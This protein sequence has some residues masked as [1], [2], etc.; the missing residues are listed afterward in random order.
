[1]SSRHWFWAIP[2]VVLLLAAA[3]L[4]PP[5]NVPRAVAAAHVTV[6]V[7]RTTP[8]GPSQLALGVTH[9][10]YSLDP[11]G[12][13]TAVASG[14]ALL[15]AATVYQ[16]QSIYG[17]GATNPEPSPGVYDWSNLDQRL[18][19]IRA[20]G[21]TPVITLCCA[22]DWMTSLDTPTSSD[23]RLPPTMAHYADFANLA[24]QVALRYPDVKYYQVWNEM[25][26]FW[27][28][29]TNNW[30]YAAYTSMYNAVYDALK[31]VSPD[32]KV[33]G[34]YL[35]LEGTGASSLGVP[36]TW[37]TA[38]PITARNRQV[39]TYWL[40]NKHGADFVCVDHAVVQPTQ[41]T[42]SY[43]EAQLLQLTHWFSDILTQLRSLTTLPIWFAEDYFDPILDAGV[44]YD[45][46]FQAVIQA[47]ILYHEVVGGAAVALHWQP[48]G[49][50]TK[51]YQG[52]QESLFSDTR[53]AGGGQPFP[54]Y[55]VFKAIH[56]DFPP[57]TQLYQARSSSPD[58]AVLASATQTLLLNKRPSSTTVSVDG[59]LLTLAGYDVRVLAASGLQA[60]RPR[61]LP[62]QRPPHPGWQ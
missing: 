24:R 14:K 36:A 34:P 2:V 6:T 5:G 25:K 10:Q 4:P 49:V 33:G 53:V 48:Q 51:A 17:W 28:S 22:P 62:P 12:D 7:D 31:A 50:S 19:L 21:G 15:A 54:F 39:L 43:T 56:D 57:G 52:D 30:D 23:P 16:N 58:V 38:D 13:P 61:L 8:A 45:H 44:N 20:T 42:N 1:M 59:T 55:G 3:G 29:A 18:N 46:S 41:D 47:S 26:G 37:A 35:V 9:T 40:A 11:S 60:P 32:I 27:N